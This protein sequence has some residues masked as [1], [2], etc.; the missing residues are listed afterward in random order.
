MRRISLCLWFASCLVGLAMTGSAS[1]GMQQQLTPKQLL[2]KALYF[3]A[4]L[5]SPAGQ[6]CSTCHNPEAGWT[7]PG[8]YTNM[9]GAVYEGAVK[10]RFGNRK[11][12]SAAYATNSPIF[13]KKD[14]YFMG[15]NF[16]D[17]RATGELLGNPA[18]DQALG[19][20]LN[21]LEMNNPSPQAVCESVKMSNFA[22]HL[23]GYSYATLFS[24]AFGYGSLDCSN[25][26]ETYYRIGKAIAAYEG[27]KEVN[28]Y[29]SKYDYYRAGKAQLTYE[30]KW[31]MDLFKGKAKCSGCH[32]LGEFTDFRFHNLGI[33]KNPENPFYT[34]YMFNPQG[35]Y[36]IDPGLKGFLETRPD[37]WQYADANYG[38][39]RTQTLRNVD[40]RTIPGFVKA[41]MHNGSLKSLKEVVHF[42][43]TRDT[44]F[45]PEPEVP[46]DLSMDVGNLYLTD[47]EENA[48]VAFM[49]T[50]SDGY[51]M[52][53]D[54]KGLYMAYCMSC[55]GSADPSYMA[56]APTAP[57]RVIGA[58][59]CS[60]KGAINGTYVF[61]GGVRAMKFMQGAFSDEQIQKISDYLN[62]FAGITGQQRFITTCAG[63][64]GID[65]KGGRVDEE[66]YGESAEDIKEAI[67]DESPMKFLK[68]LP[69]SDICAI[70]SYLYMMDDDYH[71][72]DSYYYMKSGYSSHDGD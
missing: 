18:A 56:A 24:Q 59:S 29:S 51:M 8:S 62:S 47:A 58:R 38:K 26:M 31:G 28:Q 27:S 45:W 67:Y 17:G 14:G 41:Y 52:P 66:V 30:E 46:C 9:H 36:W 53:P 1:A 2:G 3:D 20:F 61:K 35:Y 23:T 5:S 60:I 13:S 68:C 50:L 65:A 64:H 70:G 54:G 33:P 40:K 25:Y 49:K 11:P 19:P 6:S 4:R 7:G 72:D 15:G 55:H 44:A 12:N 37:Y 34:Q 32:P 22:E 39:H 21:P 43:N 10:G 48:L 57:R 69:Y 42:M 71:G 16:W 63:C